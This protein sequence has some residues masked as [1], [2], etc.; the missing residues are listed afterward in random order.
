M[1]GPLNRPFS[2]GDADSPRL[3]ENLF[4]YRPST[5]LLLDPLLSARLLKFPD[6]AVFS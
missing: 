1:S 5:F 2:P 4:Y 6:L 3:F